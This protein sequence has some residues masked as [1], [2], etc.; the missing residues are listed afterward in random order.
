MRKAKSLHNKIH[1]ATE[2]IN[3]QRLMS[4]IQQITQGMGYLHAKG[5]V[6]TKLNSHNISLEPKVKI[7]LMDYGMAQARFDR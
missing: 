4:I 6:M 5:I 3:P 2:T 1:L 7:C